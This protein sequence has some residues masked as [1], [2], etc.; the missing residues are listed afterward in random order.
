MP[1][2]RPGE[3]TALRICQRTARSETNLVTAG[4]HDPTQC[5]K[6]LITAESLVLIEEFQVWKRFGCADVS[7]MN[8]R[9]VEALSILENEWQK[10][11]ESINKVEG[12]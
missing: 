9:K 4:R 3:N 10:E 1:K 2:T 11:I 7:L 5:P 6:S 8:A 12:A